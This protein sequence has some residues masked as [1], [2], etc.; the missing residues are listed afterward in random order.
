MPP[1]LPR[2]TG[3]ST[4]ASFELSLGAQ[5]KLPYMITSYLEA[6]AQ[7]DAFIG[8]KGMPRDVLVIRREHG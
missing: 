7:L 1:I 8:A 2:A 3:P 5:R 6:V 4:L